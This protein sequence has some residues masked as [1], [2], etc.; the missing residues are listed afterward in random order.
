LAFKYFGSRILKLGSVGDDVTVLQTLLSQL[1]PEI[2][3]PISGESA[4]GPKT[5]ASVKKFQAYFDL[6]VDGQVGKNTFM[7][8][9][10]ITGA[11][12]FG[13]RTLRIGKSGN[14]VKILQNRLA[15]NLKRYANV[16]GVPADGYFG[17]KT[18]AAVKLFQTE[19]GLTADGI[20]AAKTFNKLYVGT[21]YGGRILQADRADRNR[22]YDVYF[23]QERLKNLGYYSGS[24]DGK[25]GPATEAAV[26]ALQTAANIVVDG[27]VGS[28][29]YFYLGI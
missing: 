23:L 5:K 9:G 1:P 18:Q 6:K 14:D 10:Q 25:F 3:L 27:V 11:C 12:T 16:L 17:S 7:Y 2:A 20:V 4:F 22:G 21:H 13:A 29:T 28:Q 19:K 15:G 24:L 26:K 8:L